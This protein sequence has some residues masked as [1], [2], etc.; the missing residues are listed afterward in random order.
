MKGICGVWKDGLLVNSRRETTFSVEPGFEKAVKSFDTIS[1]AKVLSDIVDFELDWQSGM[2]YD[3]LRSRYHFKPLT[4]FHRPYKLYEIYVGPKRKHLSYRAAMIFYDG[5][6]NA[7]WMH[8]FKKEKMNERQ[9]VN[10]VVE[11]A[12]KFWSA[13]GRKR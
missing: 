7:R 3:Q 9:D 1:A 5:Q 10:L 11:R 13:I 8:A 6:S 12:D 2:E 4:G